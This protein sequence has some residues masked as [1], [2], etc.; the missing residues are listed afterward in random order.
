[1]ISASDITN[2]VLKKLVE[3]ASA[4]FGFDIVYKD[5]S[6]FMKTLAIFATLFNPKFMTDYT[7]TV[8]TTIYVP[9]GDFSEYQNDY[10]EIF[11]HELMHMRENKQQGSVLYF[12][13][14]FFPQ[15]LF[16]LALLSI[17]AI[18][19]LWFLLALLF[20]LFLLP[21]PS[22]GRR[23][24]ELNGYTMSLAVRYWTGS[25]LDETDFTRIERYFTGSAYYFMW[26]FAGGIGRDLRERAVRIRS[27]DILSDRLFREICMIVKS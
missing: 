16:P 22:P 12:L 17:G 27:G 9:R 1:M 19:N 7:T 20:L 15:I 6:R 14:Y 3:Y 5:E 21:L 11:A 18:W 23:D 10:V 13:R 4:E 26:P 25:Q 24:I 2:P 8:G